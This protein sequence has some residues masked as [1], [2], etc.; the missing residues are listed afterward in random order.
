MFNDPSQ[1]VRLICTELAREDPDIECLVAQLQVDYEI[2]DLEARTVLRDVV[3]KLNEKLFPPLTKLELILV[4][5]CN[6]AC[7][8]C[9]ESQFLNS[10][11]LRRRMMDPRV[12]RKAVD[13]LFDY[14]RDAKELSITLFGGEPTLHMAGIREA[15]SYANDLARQHD[16]TLRYDMTSSG[17][18]FTEEM[19]RYFAG[20]GIMVLLSIDGTKTVHDKYRLDKRGEGTFD[21]VLRGLDLLKEVQPWIGT[22]MTVMPDVA[23]SLLESIRYLYHRGVNQFVIG[24]A[25]GADWTAQSLAQYADQMAVARKWYLETRDASGDIRITQFDEEEANQRGSFFGCGA[26]RNTVAV[27]ASGK[28][29]GCSRI[30]TVDG[31]TTVGQLGDVDI[32]IFN[33]N[34]RS[35]MSGCATLK[36][37]CAEAGIASEFR[38]GCFATNYEANKD[39]FSPN[40]IEHEISLKINT[41]NG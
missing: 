16:K 39:L 10:Q 24:H 29:T 14:S 31:H 15:V 40:M 20:N 21:S 6:L 12:I 13:L 37:N 3:A 25:T 34:V 32:G 5:G 33:L 9:F 17:V 30:A 4:E 26:G 23:G 1:L 18:L 19:V 36:R 8:Y 27:E 7:R 35:E 22:K 28:I 38:G 2:D 11:H 41:A